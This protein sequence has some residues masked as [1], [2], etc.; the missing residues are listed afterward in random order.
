MRGG[1]G[2]I[3]SRL[4][5]EGPI[6][7]GHSSFIVSGRR[8]YVDIF[9]RAINN[10]NAETNPEAFQIPDYY[11]YDLNTKINYQIGEK[12][13]IFLSGYFG[14]DVFKFDD[15]FFDFNFNWGNATGTARWNHQFSPRLFSNTTFTYSDYEY[16]IENVIT[17]FSFQ[18]RF[19]HTR[20]SW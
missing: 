19:A 6:Q 17:D 13:R 8:T 11:F 10:S 12:D 2:L 7:K 5:L 18:S 14:R 16:E 15:D 20:C 1:I 9:T 4:T 3:S